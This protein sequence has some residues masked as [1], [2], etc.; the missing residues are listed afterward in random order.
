LSTRV[1]RTTEEGSYRVS[2]LAARLTY[3][4]AAVA[5]TMRTV[6]FSDPPIPTFQ[7]RA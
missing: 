3:F 4:E 5:H 7:D 6:V 1:A 2:V